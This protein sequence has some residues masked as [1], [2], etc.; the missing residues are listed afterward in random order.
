MQDKKLHNLLLLAAQW[1]V[2]FSLSCTLPA[3]ACPTRFYIQPS[4]I[5][6]W[7]CQCLL[8]Q[9]FVVQKRLLTKLFI[10]KHLKGQFTQK[11][12]FSVCHHLL[13]FFLC[14]TQKKIFLRALG[15]I[16]KACI[17]TNFEHFHEQ[18]MIH[19]RISY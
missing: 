19:Q 3:C 9:A 18:I 4:T 14:V 5:P 15:L 16:H 2:S 6:H 8:N 17:R 13:D 12:L 7:L 11:C 10:L 1:K